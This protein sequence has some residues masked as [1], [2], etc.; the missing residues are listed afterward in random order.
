MKEQATSK[1]FILMYF[2]NLWTAGPN[3][4]KHKATKKKTKVYFVDTIKII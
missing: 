1:Y 3:R 4:L 2:E